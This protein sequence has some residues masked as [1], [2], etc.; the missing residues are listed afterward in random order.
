MI[1]E[2]VI[3]DATNAW[4]SRTRYSGRKQSFR[5]KR[6]EGHPFA[7]LEGE[8]RDGW[9]TPPTDYKFT[10][11]REEAEIG[12]YF[13][14]A[15]STQSVRSWYDAQLGH[16]AQA[17][18]IIPNPAS[19]TGY[20][21]YAYSYNNP[22]RYVDPSGHDPVLDE[23]ESVINDIEE[24]RSKYGLVK[25]IEKNFGIVFNK[26]DNWRLDELQAVNDGLE[27]IAQTLASY[28]TFENADPYSVFRN[29]F[30]TGISGSGNITFDKYNSSCDN[31]Y[32]EVMNSKTI[33]WY[34]NGWGKIDAGLVVH[35]MGH[36]FNAVLGGIPYNDIARTSM[37]DKPNGFSGG[38]GSGYYSKSNEHGE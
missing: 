11:Q 20:D 38:F 7:P 21:R 32:A 30:N 2:T 19:A 26:D 37:P 9:G 22:V 31:C 35:E 25:D 36:V 15:E 5:L 24:E 6:M 14:Q 23:D 17:D 4:Q 8:E 28:T 3:D 1:R 33:N 18:T 34:K 12:L 29:L 10:G 16:F 13:Y 27:A